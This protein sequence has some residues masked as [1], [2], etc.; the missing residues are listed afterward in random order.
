ML[1]IINMKCPEV[2]LS[3]HHENIKKWRID[4]SI[5]KTKL[6]RPDLIKKNKG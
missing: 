4:K 3:G 5:E 1:K 2:L 6:I